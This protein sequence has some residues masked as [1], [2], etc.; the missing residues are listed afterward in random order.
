VFGQQEQQK[1]SVSSQQSGSKHSETLSRGSSKQ[2]EHQSAMNFA[3]GVLSSIT[4]PGATAELMV[5]FWIIMVLLL[6]S[7]GLIVLEVGLDIYTIIMLIL[8]SGLGL[9][10]AW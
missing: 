8:W 3:Q 7:V 2:T 10:L 1:G 4:T 9:S 5:A 6:L